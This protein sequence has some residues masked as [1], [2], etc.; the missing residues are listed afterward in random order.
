[1]YIREDNTYEK[2]NIILPFISAITTL[3]KI[4]LIEYISRKNESIISRKIIENGYTETRARLE[5]P[6]LLTKIKELNKIF[7]PSIISRPLPYLS[8]LRSYRFVII[9]NTI[10]EGGIVFNNKSIRYKDIEFTI[11]NLKSII[12]FNITKAK[13]LLFS[14]LLYL[15]YNLDKDR[16]IEDILPKIPFSSLID[17][18]NEL[19]IRYS[20]LSD[21]LKSPRYN[22]DNY[23]VKRILSIKE[24][25]E[26]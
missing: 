24:L 13:E 25:R 26:A 8:L 10:K 11:S 2:V 17:N 7:I 21:I 20:F 12:R 22:L 15:D 6:S 3:P 4:F 9:N 23:L 19:K 18:F 16:A 5:T 14:N 1:M